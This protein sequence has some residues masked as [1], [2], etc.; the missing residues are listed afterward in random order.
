MRQT[1]FSQS[2]MTWTG[3]RSRAPIGYTAHRLTQRLN[4]HHWRSWRM[5][6]TLRC[7]SRA[8]QRNASNQRS[9]CTQE[10][11]ETMCAGAVNL[12]SNFIQ[13]AGPPPSF[14]NT[15]NNIITSYLNCLLNYIMIYYGAVTSDF[16][17]DICMCKLAGTD[18]TRQHIIFTAPITS[19]PHF[20]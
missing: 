8:F 14:N 3:L 12:S 17:K 20:F 13:S 10:T 11:P 4:C 9:I 19:D 5:Q 1:A 18:H 2:S 6:Q 7:A 16:N 15:V